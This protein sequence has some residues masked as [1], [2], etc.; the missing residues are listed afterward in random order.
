MNMKSI[1]R[2]LG[3]IAL[4]L[5]GSLFA[6]TQVPNTFQAGQPARATEVNE[7]FSTLSDAVDTNAAAIQNFVLI[8]ANQVE[9]GLAQNLDPHGQGTNHALVWLQ[10]GADTVPLLAYKNFIG[11]SQNAIIVYD[12]AG[13]TGTAMVRTQDTNG[14]TGGLFFIYDYFLHSDGQ[15]V[16][17]LDT[18]TAIISASW[19]SLEQVQFDGTTMVK[20]C[21]VFAGSGNA[22]PANVV[23]TLP[24]TT[25]PYS[26]KLV[27]N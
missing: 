13:C 3:I 14:F 11:N 8:D 23:G 24:V 16:L 18:S 12:G 5:S 26:I 2:A 10:I 4:M 6:Q 21:I 9:V 17:Q 27:S 25:P 20:A 19:Q 22:H 7:N 15:T 1:S